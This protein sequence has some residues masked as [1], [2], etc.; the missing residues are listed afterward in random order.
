MA[1]NWRHREGP[2]DRLPFLRIEQ[3]GD[4]GRVVAHHA[5]PEPAHLGPVELDHAAAQPAQSL[6]GA[7]RLAGR[8]IE[9]ER[10]DEARHPSRRLGV[11]HAALELDEWSREVDRGP[12]REDDVA[13]IEA[14]ALE[15]AEMLREPL[16]Q[17]LGPASLRG[18]L[19][20]GHEHRE[21]PRVL[22]QHVRPEEVL[23]E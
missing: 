4:E 10:P 18:E 13:V 2:L 11:L 1:R 12:V 6:D 3:V 21:E 22:H 23:R 14:G 5:G 8:V 9:E 15:P 16:L 19:R 7:L 17:V 20:P